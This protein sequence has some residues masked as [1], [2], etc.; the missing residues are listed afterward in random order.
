MALS[1]RFSRLFELAENKMETVASMFSLGLGQGGDGWR[2]RRRLW[3]WEE[4]L[5]EECRAFM[6]DVS[7]FPNVSD[8]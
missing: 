3:V 8:V 4:N 1:E 7:L 2:W 6:L 5:L